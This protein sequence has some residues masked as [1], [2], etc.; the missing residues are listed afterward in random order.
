MKFYHYIGVNNKGGCTIAYDLIEH[1]QGKTLTFSVGFCSY[2]DTY[3]KKKG[4]D[5]ALKQWVNGNKL[6]IVYKGKKKELERRL[7][8][9]ATVLVRTFDPRITDF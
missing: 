2:K 5:A 1:E 9:I 6:N 7:P 4:R 3:C 8:T